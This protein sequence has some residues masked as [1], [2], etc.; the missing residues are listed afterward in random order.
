MYSLYALILRC[1]TPSVAERLVG[2]YGGLLS[3]DTFP[4][5]FQIHINPTEKQV[6]E[7][8]QSLPC[9]FFLEIGQ[10]DNVVAKKWLLE[11]FENYRPL[12]HQLVLI[13]DQNM[14]YF[15]LAIQFQAGNILFYES[16]DAAS[17]GAMTHRLLG[18]DF[19][20]FAPFFPQGWGTNENHTILTGKINLN[21]VV[22]RYFSKFVNAVPEQMRNALQSQISE[23]LIN[24]VSYGILEITPEQRDSH[25]IQ[26]PEIIEIPPGKEIRISMVLDHEKYG[27]SVRDPG[28]SLTLLRIM[29]KLRRHTKL[30]GQ[31][32]PIGLEDLTGRGLFIVSRQTRIVV[33][34]LRGEQ[35]EVILLSYFHEENNCYKP[36]IINEKYPRI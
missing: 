5:R 35:T 24:A 34:I 15:D 21:G 27:I 36:L 13:T 29:Q 9:L 23:L 12:G 25:S 14:D 3:Q 20:G 32:H 2:V 10:G 19:F 28:G 18:R 8:S 16:I 31:P 22:E 33:N 1:S 6:Q 17:V 30:P 26:I 7:L 11:M 4:F